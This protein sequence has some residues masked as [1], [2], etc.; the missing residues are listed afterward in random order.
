MILYRTGF[1]R[2]A[3]LMISPYVVLALM[4]A[5]FIGFYMGQ[6]DGLTF[7]V[8]VPLLFAIHFICLL[9][10]RKSEVPPVTDEVA[11]GS[12]VFV[13]LVVTTLSVILSMLATV[14]TLEILYELLYLRGQLDSRAQG[15]EMVWDGFHVFGESVIAVI[16]FAPLSYLYFKS[17]RKGVRCLL[18]KL[19][20]ER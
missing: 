7:L 12:D 19:I 18:G 14:V 15:Q 4:M 10:Y 8:G 9:S 16:L 2:A 11:T 6:V 1:Q 5:W 17:I 20:P 13:A 3:S